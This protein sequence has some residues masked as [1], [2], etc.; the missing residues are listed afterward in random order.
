MNTQQARKYAFMFNPNKNIQAEEEKRQAVANLIKWEEA[1][2]LFTSSKLNKANYWLSIWNTREVF[3]VLMKQG[4][5]L[6]KNYIQP[7]YN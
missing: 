6:I 7:D 4:L 2:K 3:S 5:S 1:V